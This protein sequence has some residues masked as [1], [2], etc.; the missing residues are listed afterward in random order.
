[1]SQVL[2]RNAQ[3]VPRGAATLP[4]QEKNSSADAQRKR[5]NFTRM[6][7]QIIRMRVIT[8]AFNCSPAAASRRAK[9]DGDICVPTLLVAQPLDAQQFSNGC[10]R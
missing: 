1:V 10:S 9:Y 4:Q 2:D 5:A 8:A 3:V 6:Q 7:R